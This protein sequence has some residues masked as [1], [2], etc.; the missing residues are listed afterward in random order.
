[1]DSE[2]MAARRVNR[3]TLLVAKLDAALKR[4]AQ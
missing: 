1:M 2:S 3:A 4:I